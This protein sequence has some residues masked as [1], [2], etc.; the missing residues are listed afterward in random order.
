M[1]RESVQGHVTALTRGLRRAL[2]FGLEPRG[3]VVSGL[4]RRRPWA[5]AGEHGVP[6]AVSPLRAGCGAPLPASEGLQWAGVWRVRSPLPE[7]PGASRP[8]ALCASKQLISL[9]TSSIKYI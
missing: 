7:A 9:Y 4:R 6:G 3:T 1:C 5:L 8:G 2:A